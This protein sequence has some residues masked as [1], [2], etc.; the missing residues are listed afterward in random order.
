M[1]TVCAYAERIR[2][3]L[4]AGSVGSDAP[5]RRL[6]DAAHAGTDT[7]E[8]L[9]ALHAVLQT[10]DALGV[11]GYAADPGVRGMRWQ[12]Q[13]AHAPG[14]RPDPGDES[15]FLCPDDRCARYWLPEP[16]ASVPTCAISGTRM[17]RDRL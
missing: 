12:A 15:V 13:G 11:D 5:L 10:E 1:A 6:I 8:P 16:G 4:V 2:A 9:E 17:R 7:A 14:L 3:D